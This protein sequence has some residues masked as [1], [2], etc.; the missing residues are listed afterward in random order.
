MNG[1]NRVALGLIGFFISFYGVYSAIFNANIYWYS[2][3]V[4]GSFLFFD[5]L[6]ASVNKDS[7][8]TRLLQGHW[9]TVCYSYLTFILSAL[10]IDLLIARYIADMFLYQHYD[11][12]DFFI[13]VILIGYPFAFLSCSALYRF[14]HG[15]F[16]RLLPFMPPPDIQ[17]KP[18][19][20][21]IAGLLLFGTILSVI[22][23]LIN[24]IFFKN[25]FVH[26]L[27]VICLFIGVFSLSP[28]KLILGKKCLLGDM[29][30]G[31]RAAIFALLVAI[32]INAF[33]HEIPNTFIWEWRY[34]DIPFTSMQIMNVHILVLTIGWTCL[35]F[36]G[37]SGNDLFFN[38][39][40][41]A[42][43]DRSPDYASRES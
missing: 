26:E 42:R 34:Q 8:I 40:A 5:P 38:S 25:R 3:F 19:L 37:A 22:L 18:Y 23:P 30:S 10:V 43:K 2:Y 21:P 11:I 27:V 17:T 35:T 28:I 7:N 36:L 13:H 12:R 16:L 41:K 39:I 6:D 1:L 31:D 29:L 14:L 4:I 24:F 15:L 32:P 9:Q 33:A 20:R